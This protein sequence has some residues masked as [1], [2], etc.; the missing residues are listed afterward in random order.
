[1]EPTDPGKLKDFAT[2]GRSGLNLMMKN[3]GYLNLS[4]MQTRFQ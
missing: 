3:L 2:F 1:M 4:A